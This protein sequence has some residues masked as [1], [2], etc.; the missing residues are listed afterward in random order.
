MVEKLVGVCMCCR[1]WII[2]LHILTK[3]FQVHLYLFQQDCSDYIFIFINIECSDQ[4]I[5]STGYLRTEHG[6][7]FTFCR[8]WSPLIRLSANSFLL[9]PSK[10]PLQKNL[11]RP[12]KP[13]NCDLC[14]QL[15]INL[16]GGFYLFPL[17]ATENGGEL[18]CERPT[19]NLI[20]TK[21]CVRSKFLNF[22]LQ[23]NFARTKILKFC[24][25]NPKIFVTN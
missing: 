12:H 20:L 6:H 21:I 17:F 19:T 23:K 25:K 1:C 2:L 4:V 8:N 18:H 14:T 9:F 16:E 22:W 13:I 15:R 5:F 11:D 3:S 24:H 10:N 7:D